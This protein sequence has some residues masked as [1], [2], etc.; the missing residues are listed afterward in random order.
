MSNAD[1]LLDSY[2]RSRYRILFYAVLVTLIS[3]PILSALKYSGTF[4]EMFVAASLLAAILPIASVKKWPY[5]L[6]AMML[7]C[8]ARPATAWLARPVISEI[9]L[10][11]WTIIGLIAAASAI[12]FATRATRISGEHVYAALSAYLLA[13]LCFG[14]L[15]WVIEELH[16]GT[17]ALSGKFSQTGAIYFSFI[18]LATVGYGDIAPRGD[19]ARG[20]AIVEGIGGQLFLAVLV[21]RLISLYTR[22]SDE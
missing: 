22:P 17:F 19:I 14:V 9:T 1:H 5:I 10:G 15:Y 8:L 6:P 7:L 20:I 21:A 16:P 18:T 2:L 11:V 12:R 13:G 3:G 4:L